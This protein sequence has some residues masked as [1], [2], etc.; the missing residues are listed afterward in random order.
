[1]VLQDDVSGMLSTCIS[2]VSTW[3][4]GKVVPRPRPTDEM[5]DEADGVDELL[6]VLVL[7]LVVPDVTVLLVGDIG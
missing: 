2:P 5:I 3:L 4:I 7:T 6:L 1:M